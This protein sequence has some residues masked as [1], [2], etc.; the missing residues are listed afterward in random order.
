M[1]AKILV[2][3]FP[4]R[5]KSCGFGIKVGDTISWVK[6]A[7]ASHAS[8]AACATAKA[9]FDAI[10]AAQKT[11][12]AS[13]IVAFLTAARDRGLKFP[14]ARF[15][16]PA[17][18]ELKLSLA[19]AK[20]KFPGSISVVLGGDW[21]GRITPSAEVHGKLVNKPDV[22]AVLTAIG[23]DP[24]GMAKA[25]GALTCSC[26][27]CGLG[28]TDEGSVEVGY[29]PVCAKKWGLPHKPKGA[30]SLATLPAVPEAMGVSL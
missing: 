15:L 1:T 10:P 16:G 8:S 6:G 30:P 28:L 18:A 13:P 11:F 14:K 25:Y 20:S 3:Q 23:T 2:S 7:G 19:G 26:S 27:F 5:C 24:A 12:D 21:I 22:L 29:G 4:G 17:G 9:E